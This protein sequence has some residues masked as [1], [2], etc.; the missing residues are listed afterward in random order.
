MS[1]KNLYQGAVWYGAKQHFCRIVTHKEN[2]HTLPR[3]QSV[4]L[5]PLSTNALRWELDSMC[6]PK[7]TECSLY[8]ASFTPLSIL[9]F[10]T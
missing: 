3:W 10:H 5:V 8:V 7:Y 4:G 1:S 6:L 2:V 9:P